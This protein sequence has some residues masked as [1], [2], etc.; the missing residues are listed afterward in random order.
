M[1]QDHGS[2]ARPHWPVSTFERPASKLTDV[3]AGLGPLAP[4][5]EPPAARS[6]WPN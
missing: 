6:C 3:I 5:W 1:L 4:M 2:P